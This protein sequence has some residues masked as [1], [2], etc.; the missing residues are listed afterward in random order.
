MEEKNTGS[1]YAKLQQQFHS[2]LR[3]LSR[4]QVT[5]N[6]DVHKNKFDDDYR[7]VCNNINNITFYSSLQSNI[8]FMLIYTCYLSFSNHI[9]DVTIYMSFLKLSLLPIPQGDSY[10]NPYSI[11]HAL[12]IS[13]LIAS[14]YHCRFSLPAYYPLS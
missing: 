12:Y 7:E 1:L 14:I 13:L 2:T 10:C 4:K 8:S 5:E 3:E 6:A 9:F 11:I